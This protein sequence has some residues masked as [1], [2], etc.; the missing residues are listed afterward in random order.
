[1]TTEEALHGAQSFEIILSG[2]TAM[3]SLAQIA[4]LMVNL[5]DAYANFP[6]GEFA[7]VENVMDVFME[8]PK[9]Y[10]MDIRGLRSNVGLVLE[11][12]NRVAPYDKYCGD[13]TKILSRLYVCGFS[14][15]HC[16]YFLLQEKS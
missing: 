13:A 16:T 9:K 11:T 15:Q 3:L 4:Y 10:E 14:P 1:M 12:F 5:T 7:M 8:L 2:G 6:R